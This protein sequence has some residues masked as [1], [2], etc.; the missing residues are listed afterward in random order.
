MLMSTAKRD[1]LDDMIKGIKGVDVPTDMQI[2]RMT[3]HEIVR[4]MHAEEEYNNE[5]ML[6]MPSVPNEV[7]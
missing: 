6:P 1:C 4:L 5:P 3:L 7:I 2:I